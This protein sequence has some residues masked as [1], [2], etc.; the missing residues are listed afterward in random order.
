MGAQDFHRAHQCGP[1]VFPL[2]VTGLERQ[3]GLFD[4]QGKLTNQATPVSFS[5]LVKS[6]FFFVF[7]YINDVSIY[8]LLL[9]LKRAQEAR[10][11]ASTSVSVPR[12][13]MTALRCPLEIKKLKRL[14]LSSPFHPSSAASVLLTFTVNKTTADFL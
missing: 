7:F 8:Y 3:F 2:Q 6:I 4:R 5:L 11:S 13:V 9:P 14:S 12:L 1:L 10:W